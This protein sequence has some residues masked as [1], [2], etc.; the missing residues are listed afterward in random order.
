MPNTKKTTRLMID[1]KIPLICEKIEFN[2]FSIVYHVKC[3]SELRGC[4]PIYCPEDVSY[5]DLLL[6]PTLLSKDNMTVIYTPSNVTPQFYQA[7][8]DKTIRNISEYEVQRN[9]I[10]NIGDIVGFITL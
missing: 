8:L 7:I 5:K 6:K 4:H 3:D 2:P 10:Y 9:H 1:N